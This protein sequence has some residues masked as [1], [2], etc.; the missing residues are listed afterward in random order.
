MTDKEMIA[1]TH[2]KYGRRPT[3]WDWMQVMRL[4]GSAKQWRELF[5]TQPSKRKA[6]YFA[7]LQSSAWQHKRHGALERANGRCSCGAI[8]AEIHHNTYERL[9]DEADDDLEAKCEVCHRRIHGK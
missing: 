3:F 2:V 1:F 7:Y 4:F 8:A 5:A 9:G 6:Y